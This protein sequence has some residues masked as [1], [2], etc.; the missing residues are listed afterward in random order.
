MSLTK[1]RRNTLL[2]LSLA[3]CLWPALSNSALAQFARL[4]QV[5]GG[6]VYLRRSNWSNFYRT[7]PRTMLLGDDLLNV[8]VNAEVVLLCPDGFLTDSIQVGVSNVSATCVGT[9]RSV[10]PTFG[11][12]ESWDATDDTVPYIISP[13]SEQVRTATPILRWH[14]VGGVEQYEVTL[15]QR[16]GEN[17]VDVWTVM[18][19]RAVMAYPA[20]QQGLE[21]GTDYALQVTIPGATPS[22]DTV[23]TK[24]FILL[25]G[26]DQQPLAEDIA[27]VEAFDVDPITQTLI[28][29]EEVYPRY[30]LFAQ[31]IN[32]L[33]ALIEAGHGNEL[34]YRLL[35]DYHIRSGLARP[36]ELSYLQ[37]VELAQASDNL[38][39]EALAAWGLGTLYGRT[40]QAEEACT[41]L[42]QA[43]TL[44]TELGDT[45]LSPQ[46]V[47]ILRL[48][49]S[50]S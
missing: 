4:Y 46:A 24:V 23:P 18:S 13:W 15:R 28:L 9:P 37:A 21:A 27:E 50:Y 5:E 14:D 41:Y 25:D 20:D 12:S 19:D 33:T 30:K 39:E 35:G 17:W 34:I 1:R 29:V 7:H 49:A 16:D 40:G 31:G 38:E 45:N 48:P 10:R 36:A 22:A 26:G 8:E 32:E 43:Q 2:T 11:I 42:Q 6:A 47:T 44:A 3:A